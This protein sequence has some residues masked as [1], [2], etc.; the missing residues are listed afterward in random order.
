MINEI[1]QVVKANKL[2][3]LMVFVAFC[4]I[5]GPTAKFVNSYIYYAA[6]GIFAIFNFGGNNTKV[7]AAYI[8][9]I[10][11][12]VASLT[13]ND[14][15]PEFKAWQRLLFFGTMIIPI[16]SF[17]ENDKFRI[18]RLYAF[19]FTLWM[20]VFVGVASFICYLFG[21]NFMY[22]F[23]SG[24]YSINTAGWFGGI[25]VH[26]MLMGPVSALGATFMTWYVTDGA[27]RN[28]KKRYM[29]YFCIFAC[30]AAAI[31]SA[32][33]GSTVAAVLGSAV[34]YLL[35]NG[36]SGGK[37]T[38][39]LL[40]LLFIG[41]VIQPLMT[42]FTAMLME[43]QSRNIESGGTFES[44]QGKWENRIEE[45]ESSP[46]YGSGFCTVSA[47]SS[48]Y[49]EGGIVETGTSWLA[50]L[51]MLG[52]V[53]A[54]CIFVIVFKPVMLIYRRMNRTDVLFFGI[55]CVFLL[56]MATEGY[57]FAGGN[58]MF[59]CFWLF[60]GAMHAYLSNPNYKFV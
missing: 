31:L 53:G 22:N 1:K 43:K 2:P 27:A 12:A 23:V 52:I 59:F 17:I 28:K 48:D 19:N 56:H 46:I 57:I 7:S 15:L 58:F 6:L 20:S 16:S 10:I 30:V 54:I 49:S 29:Y 41:I 21:I 60:V 33:R 8:A 40:G 18:K 50:V 47:N 34:V 24:E 5:L 45:F 26:S 36:K 44:R 13:F 37:I 11:G 3:A 35:R 4:T 55:F 14:V 51:S 32:S 42:P 25:T 39:G 9:L 38:T